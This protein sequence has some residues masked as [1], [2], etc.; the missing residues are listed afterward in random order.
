MSRGKEREGK[1]RKGKEREGEVRQVELETSDS[2]QAKIYVHDS[3]GQLNENESKEI[4]WRKIKK[5]T[6]KTYSSSNAT[7]LADRR[8]F[9]SLVPCRQAAMQHQLCGIQQ[10]SR[11]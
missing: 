10:V 6:P 5:V 7:E 2:N 8:L 3:K 1:G 4:V 9:R 11:P